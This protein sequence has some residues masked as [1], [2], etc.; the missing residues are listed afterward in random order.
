LAR[1]GVND[2]DALDIYMPHRCCTLV[3]VVKLVDAVPRPFH[4]PN[5][6]A[7]NGWIHILQEEC[8][9]PRMPN[10]TVRNGSADIIKKPEA[11]AEF[12][13]TVG[14]ITANFEIWPEHQT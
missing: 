10:G 8:V 2:V 3:E 9:T 7:V 4:V 12:A 11:E 5:H 6:Q 14:L 13:R 1:F